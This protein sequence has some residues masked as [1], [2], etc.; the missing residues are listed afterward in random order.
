MRN[1]EDLMEEDEY[2]ANIYTE[3]EALIKLI[4]TYIH[5]TNLAFYYQLVECDHVNSIFD[6]LLITLIINYSL[7]VFIN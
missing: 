6:C 7:E 3:S 4:S 5:E 2:L 1:V